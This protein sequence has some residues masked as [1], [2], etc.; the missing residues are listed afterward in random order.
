[1]SISKIASALAWAFDD[2]VE[3]DKLVI[4]HRR[5]GPAPLTW[6]EGDNFSGTLPVSQVEFQRDAQGNITGFIAGNGRARD[7]LFEKVGQ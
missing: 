2:G 7:I 1:M 3:D 4:N 5:F 6:T